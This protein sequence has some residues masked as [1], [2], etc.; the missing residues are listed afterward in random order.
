LR[1]PRQARHHHAQ[2]HPACP[3]HPW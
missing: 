1:H 2:G 3:P